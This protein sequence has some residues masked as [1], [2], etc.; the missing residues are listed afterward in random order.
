MIENSFDKNQNFQFLNLTRELE[1]P[2][3][4]SENSTYDFDFKN[5]EKT[6]ES[7]QGISVSLKYFIKV[8]IARNYGTIKHDE[9]FIVYNPEEPDETSTSI[10]LEVGI[11]ECLHI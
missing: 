2:G 4:L 8:T 11:E 7:Y 3:T 6:Y 10:K 5:V 9:L 1:P